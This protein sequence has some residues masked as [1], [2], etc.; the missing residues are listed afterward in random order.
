MPPIGKSRSFPNEPADFC[1]TLRESIGNR[2]E[3]ACNP[4][5]VAGE[6]RLP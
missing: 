4:R 2:P 1:A 3:E 5:V 6:V